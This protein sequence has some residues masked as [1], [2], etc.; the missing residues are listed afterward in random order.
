MIGAFG[1]R[2]MESEPG[3][4]VGA[5][6]AA[7][8]RLR[9]VN[10]QVVV[11]IATGR[12]FI[13]DV[14]APGRCEYCLVGDAVNFAARLMGAAMKGAA[15]G[16]MPIVCDETTRKLAQSMEFD[17]VEGTP[18]CEPGYLQLKGKKRPVAAFK[19]RMS[20]V[21]RQMSQNLRA[22]SSH[23]EFASRAGRGNENTSFVGREKDLKLLDDAL[24]A[25]TEKCRGSFVAVHGPAGIGKSTLIRQAL[26]NR[27][28]TEEFIGVFCRAS[29]TAVPFRPISDFFQ[30]A[31]PGSDKERAEAAIALLI[32][33]GFPTSVEIAGLLQAVNIPCEESSAVKLLRGEDKTGQTLNI[34]IRLFESLVTLSEHAIVVA[35]E[36]LHFADPHT[37]K[38]LEAMKPSSNLFILVTVRPMSPLPAGLASALDH[39]AGVR[40]NLQ[41]L[42]SGD[43]EA[44]GCSAVGADAMG[45]R[46]A[47]SIIEKAQGNPF[48]ARELTSHL[49]HEGYV[50]ISGDEGKRVAEVSDKFHVDALPVSIERLL[51]ARVDFLNAQ[52]QHLLKL[53]SILGNEFSGAELLSCFEVDV[54]SSVSISELPDILRPAADLVSL[55]DTRSCEFQFTHALVCRPTCVSLARDLRSVFAHLK[56]AMIFF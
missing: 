11:G 35:F 27:S 46:L 50:E 55:T 21:R 51:V 19:P 53:A 49:F 44:V 20:R 5:A 25:F 17:P 56:F 36:D 38:V 37:F 43:V 23:S 28:L 7:V 24:L 29:G 40:V 39:P 30:A 45:P 14:G 33:G 52:I 31:L 8:S 1:L 54:A 42:Q 9:A 41:Q 47:A 6:V 3:L 16:T 34:I 2:G 18:G 48:F 26:A 10:Q 15:G 12:T 13:G 4:E 32:D 22:T